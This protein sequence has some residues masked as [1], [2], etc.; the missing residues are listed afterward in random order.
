MSIVARRV[1]L[2]LLAVGTA[3]GASFGMWRVLTVNGFHVL[4]WPVL[5]LFVILVL[6]AA[7]AFWT[8]LFGFF[9]HLR[10][11]DPLSLVRAPAEGALPDLRRFRTA[12][13]IPAYNEDTARL[14]AGLEATYE[15]VERTGRL[16]HFDFFLLSDT[17]DP[18]TWI[19]EELAFDELRRRVADPGRLFYRN[20]RINLERKA[21][22]I[23]DFCAAWG[24]RYRYMVVFDADS[25]MTGKSLVDLVWLMERHPGVGILQ[26]PP[27]AVNRQSLFGRLLQFATR[28]YGPTFISGLNFWQAGEA[29]YWGHNAIVR[30]RPFVEH[31][32]L[33]RLPGREP[34][35]GSIL[36]HDFVEAALMRRAGWKV[37]LASEL[38][39][40]Y[41]EI[42][43]NLHGHAARDR[44][45]C[46]G[47]LQHARLLTLPGLNWINRVHLAMGVM[48]YAAS[49]LW[50][51]MLLFG[52]AEGLRGALA[53]HE[54]FAPERSP[55]PVWEVSILDRA[56]PLL[57]SVLCLLLV[58]K[59]LALVGW[60]SGASGSPS[61]FGGRAR[62]A[63]SVLLEILFSVLLAPVL[64]VLHTRFVIATLAGRRV[65]WSPPERGEAPTP[66]REAL[67]WHLGLTVLGAL[68]SVLLF[69][70]E[71][72]LFF[73]LLPVLSGWL[74]SI[75][76]AAWT[77]R[78]GPGAWAREHGLLLTPEEV[79]PPR[80][81]A[82][83]RELLQEAAQRPWAACRDGLGWVLAD[84]AVRSVHLSLLP[85]E[86]AAQEPAARE[87]LD[88]LRSKVRTGGTGAL[89]APEARE[90]LWDAPSIRMLGRERTLDA[91]RG[92]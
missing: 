39:G 13:V 72:A 15:S 33:P 63:A 25:L 92:R 55:F 42:P 87:R 74:L 64:A 30:V 51:L 18:D 84:P 2:G 81:L 41:E 78:V 43:A 9:V 67:R 79:R 53:G 75:P 54:Y 91:A 12:V 27:V 50:M 89:D 65:S 26:T 52:T 58:P 46:Q 90:L 10:G 21:G 77:S 88:R 14:V 44:R 34:L 57:T 8:S 62:L 4:E 45:W 82:R 80:I 35:G 60:L 37:Y 71:R 19:R 6:P 59:L 5:P 47:N 38:G 73:W 17:T 11:G 49:P 83:F 40:S 29:N 48:A 32:R 68:W 70:Q 24:E 22:N 61:G 31:C 86:T 16:A 76:M 23:A 66:W 20:R 1:A 3:A 28:V 7:L 85:P 36:S 56:A 69:T